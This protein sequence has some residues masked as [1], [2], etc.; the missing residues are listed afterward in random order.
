MFAKI[1]CTKQVCMGLFSIDEGTVWDIEG[2]KYNAALNCSE[3]HI[4][5]SDRDKVWAEIP[6]KILASCFELV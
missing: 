3:I 6:D 4:A 5:E 1:R 2:V